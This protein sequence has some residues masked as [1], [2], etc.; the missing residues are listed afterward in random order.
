MTVLFVL[1]LHST[2]TLQHSGKSPKDGDVVALPPTLHDVWRTASSIRVRVAQRCL[3]NA[4]GTR[5]LHSCSCSKQHVLAKIAARLDEHTELQRVV[6][7]FRLAVRTH[8]ENLSSAFANLRKVTYS[9]VISV[10]S[11]ARFY[12]TDSR[13]M[14]FKRKH[15]PWRML[16]L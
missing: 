2:K 10:R 15:N 3:S 12:W 13:E 11:P 1:H 7:S 5:P 6:S 16:C 4:R 14:V 9:F 8:S